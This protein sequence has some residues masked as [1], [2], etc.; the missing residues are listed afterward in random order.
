MRILCLNQ[1]GP[2][3]PAPTARLLGDVAEF[4]RARGHAVTIVSQRAVDYRTQGERRPAVVGG[5]LRREVASLVRLLW[6]GWGARMEGQ[7]PEVILALSSPP[8]LLV[9]AALLARSH[10]AMLAHWAMDLYPELARELGVLRGPR[11]YG[12]IEGLMRWAYGRCAVVVT[13]DEDMRDHL[14]KTYGLS[15]VQVLS[16]WGPALGENPKSEIRNPKEDGS[17]GEEPWTWLYSGNLGRAHEWETLL[18][19]QRLLEGRGLPVHL[20]FQGSGTMRAAAAARAREL[21][22]G[23]CGWRGYAEADALAASLRGAGALVVTQR[24]AARGLLWPSKLATVERLGRPILWVGPTDGAIARRLRAVAPG[25][26]I[27]APG[28]AGAVADWVE[29]RFRREAGE[30]TGAGNGRSV[31]MIPPAARPEPWEGWLEGALALASASASAASGQA[32]ARG[33]GRPQ[34]AARAKM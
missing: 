9:L 12:A 3:D 27:F 7:R 32:A 28:A 33:C 29:A 26:G 14:E 1:Y 34:K 10:G 21:G 2:P 4:L 30:G 6:A 19:A 16:P 18:E 8:C 17:R 22:L 11:V 5:R 13:L 23:R 24:P 25:A 20:V 15:G 31:A